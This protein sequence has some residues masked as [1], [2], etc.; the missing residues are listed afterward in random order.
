MIVNYILHQ[1]T[2]F[3]YNDK[4]KV[5]GNHHVS[6]IFVLTYTRFP[7]L[8]EKPGIYFGSFNPENSLEFCVNTLN[9]LEISEKHKK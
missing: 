1:W 7:R 4:F 9:P 8:L 5:A 6:R 2:S 3:Y